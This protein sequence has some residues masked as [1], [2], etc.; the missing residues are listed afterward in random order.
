MIQYAWWSESRFAIV[1]H[2]VV[3][4]LSGML[5]WGGAGE[6]RAQERTAFTSTDAAG[7][8]LEAP[9]PAVAFHRIDPNGGMRKVHMSGV[10]REWLG[11]GFDDGPDPLLK[12]IRSALRGALQSVLSYKGLKEA[13]PSLIKRILLF[14]SYVVS[15]EPKPASCFGHA[16]SSSDS[17]SAPDGDDPKDATM[18]RPSD[19]DWSSLFGGSSSLR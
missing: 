16:A 17:A 11:P 15:V 14:L 10:H 4:L 9:H 13:R 2:L 1:R 19:V 7:P 18:T 6:A 3:L 12:G 5:P 8:M